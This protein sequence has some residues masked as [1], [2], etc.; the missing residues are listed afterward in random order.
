MAKA[1][2]TGFVSPYY[3]P[4]ARWY[5]GIFDLASAVRRGI[6]LDRIHL[7]HNVTWRGLAAGFVV[8]GLAVWLR[9]PRVWGL[10]AMTASALLLSVFIVWLGYP[11]ANLA[12]GL[13]VS[14]H[15]TGFIYYCSPVLSGWEFRGRMIFTVAVLLGIGLLVYS[16][17]R[18][19]I[20]NHWAMPVRR[21]GHV[22]V[23]EKSVSPGSIRRGDRMMYSLPGLST[24]NP[25][26]G[27]GA[28]WVQS[29][30]G[31]GPVLAIAGDRVTFSTNYFEV[32]GMRHPLQPHMPRNVTVFVPEKNWF[33]W[34]ELGIS[35]HGNAGEAA[36]SGVMMQLAMVPEKNFIGKP[37]KRW[38]GREQI[39]Q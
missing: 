10:A 18:R 4:R 24:G 23:M 33:I 17:L 14:I 29:G 16:P 22:I 15:A 12:F 30:F 5:G 38:F 37:F 39:L 26:E 36:I 2:T 21:I 8:P 31:W 35:G 11:A 27:G 20:Q 13:V 9:G 32:N 34:P 6:A 28:V 19:T 7:P 1:H 3:P 25:H